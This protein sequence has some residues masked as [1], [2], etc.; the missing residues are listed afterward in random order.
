MFYRLREQGPW[1]VTKSLMPHTQTKQHIILLFI[2]PYIFYTRLIQFWVAGELE[3]IQVV[4]G[5]VHLVWV[6]S[7]SYGRFV[8]QSFIFDSGFFKLVLQINWSLSQL[9]LGKMQGTSSPSQGYAGSNETNNRVHSH[10]L[11]G[12]YHTC[13]WMVGR[14]W[15]TLQ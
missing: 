10:F 14:R 1:T 6:A 9:L 4:R 3:P 2:H 13:F 12:S 8:I 15:T 7:L 11:P 5:G